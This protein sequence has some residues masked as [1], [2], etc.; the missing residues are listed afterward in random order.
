MWKFLIIIK[1]NGTKLFD[2][3][4]EKQNFNLNKFIYLLLNPYKNFKL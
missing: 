3:Q 2:P 4:F 1:L